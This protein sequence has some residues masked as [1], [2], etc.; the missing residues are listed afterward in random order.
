[1]NLFFYSLKVDQ[2]QSK[3]QNIFPIIVFLYKFDDAFFMMGT[4]CLVEDPLDVE[5][6]NNICLTQY[7][8]F[9][10]NCSRKHIKR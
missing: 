7:L 8:F 3:K 5:N 4:D 1:M 10:I 9:R 2:N 6:N